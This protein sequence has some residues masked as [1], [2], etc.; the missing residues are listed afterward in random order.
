MNEN[1]EDP[2]VHDSLRAQTINE[3]PEREHGLV[4][5]EVEW[6][7]ASDLPLRTGGSVLARGSA[8][9]EHI[10]GVIRE[11]VAAQSIRTRELLAARQRDLDAALSPTAHPDSLTRAAVALTL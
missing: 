3:H 7:R 8:S 6:V 11:H 1:T 5:R 9:G 2:Q 4:D 10:R